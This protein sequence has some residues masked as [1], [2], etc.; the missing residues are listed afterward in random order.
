MYTDWD[1]L[2]HNQKVERFLDTY[3]R[4]ETPGEKLLGVVSPYDLLN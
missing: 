4:I 2:T 1:A 3:R